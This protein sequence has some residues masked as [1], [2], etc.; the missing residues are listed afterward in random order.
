MASRTSELVIP[1]ATPIG[2][3]EQ[4]GEQCEPVGGDDD[5]CDQI[6]RHAGQSAGTEG[7]RS[8]P[9]SAHP[10]KRSMHRISRAPVLDAP[11]IRAL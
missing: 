3:P 9:M 11:A 5:Q 2:R 4:E 8:W 6:E 1:S 7:F 10:F